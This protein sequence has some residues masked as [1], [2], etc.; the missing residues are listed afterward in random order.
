MGKA[1]NKTSKIPFLRVCTHEER[2]R[3]KERERNRDTESGGGVN[4]PSKPTQAWCEGA[5]V[6][7]MTDRSREF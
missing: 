5:E 4:C 6:C 7:V 1:V 3:Q 2:E